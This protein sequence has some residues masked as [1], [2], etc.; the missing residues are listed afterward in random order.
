MPVYFDVEGDTDRDF[1]Y[2]VGLRFE[3]TEKRTSA[4]SG[5]DNPTDEE[6]MWMDCLASLSEIENPQL[7]TTGVSKL[8]SC[9]G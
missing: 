2:W 4:R 3:S 6:A 5:A 9:G 1:Y 8:Y 7:L